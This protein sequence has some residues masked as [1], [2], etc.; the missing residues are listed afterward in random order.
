MV[1]QFG[2]SMKVILDN[3]NIMTT[4]W[5]R[6]VCY[7][8]LKRNQV[9]ARIWSGVGSREGGWGV[10]EGALESSDDNRVVCVAPTSSAT[11]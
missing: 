3:W 6:H 9:R 4:V 7:T 5:L 2:T 10:Q 8:R 11:S 1:L